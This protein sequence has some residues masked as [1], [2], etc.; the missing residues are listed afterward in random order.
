MVDLMLRLSSEKPERVSAAGNRI[1]SA[2]TRFR[3]HDFVAATYMFEHGLIGRITAN[4][5]CVHRH[6]HV[7]RVYGT[8]ATFLYDDQGP[9]LHTVRDPEFRP[10]PVDLSPYPATKGDLIPVFVE[11]IVNGVHTAG[12]EQH[13]FDV[14]SATLAA[15]TALSKSETVEIEY[16]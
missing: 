11:S 14:M 5:G 16:V 8:K 12:N 9:R 4:F 6:Q 13:E 2:G 7:V 1:S 3:Y 10:V 15:D